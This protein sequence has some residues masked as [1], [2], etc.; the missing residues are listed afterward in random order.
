M[1]KILILAAVLASCSTRAVDLGR[2]ARADTTCTLRLVGRT[3]LAHGCAVDKLIITAAHVANPFYG[4]PAL[5]DHLAGY[6]WSDTAGNSGYLMGVAANVYRDVGVLSVAS[7]APVY[8][9]RATEE[10]RA[11]EL[12]RWIEYNS[13]KLAGA[14]APK[15]RH[16]SL[17]RTVSGHL[18]LDQPPERGASGSCVI[19]SAGLVV[20]IVSWTAPATST[21]NVAFVVSVSGPWWVE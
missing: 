1:S 2:P 3:G 5:S 6:A 18:I 11:G 12:L 21:K 7:G 13:G 20:G 9:R 16:A 8:C 4:N 19:D 10:P 14:Y 17:L 15:L